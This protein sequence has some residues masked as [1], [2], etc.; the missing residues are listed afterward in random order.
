MTRLMDQ[1]IGVREPGRIAC[2]R[3]TSF[4][5]VE[6]DIPLVCVLMSGAE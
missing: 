1:F 5:T 6:I 2:C 3:G 4:E